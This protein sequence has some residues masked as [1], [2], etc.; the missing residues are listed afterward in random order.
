MNIRAAIWPLV[1]GGAT[2]IAFVLLEQPAWL[3][4]AAATT[5]ALVLVAV[6]ER[7]SPFDR[8]WNETKGDVV[9]DTLH[10]LL[11]LAVTQLVLWS[12]AAAATFEGPW[13]A[14]RPVWQQLVVYLA[15]VEL[16]AYGAH[17]LLHSATSLWRVH[18]VHHTAERLYTINA[19]RLHPLDAAFSA[20][21]SLAWAPVVGVPES[22]VV[23]AGAITTAHLLLQHANVNSQSA[24]LAPLVATAEMHR[25]HHRPDKADSDVNYGH[26]FGFWDWLFGTYHDDVATEAHEVGVRG[27]PMARGWVAQLIAPFK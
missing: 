2:E 16:L 3:A 6:L 24:W 27:A 8:R 18:A 26:L 19:F 9:P 10:A 17:R 12:A 20:V 11:A 13:P 1:V 14:E 4:L 23:L 15:A 25:W 7:V 5:Y 21:L 22:V